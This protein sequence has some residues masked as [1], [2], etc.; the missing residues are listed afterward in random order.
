[1]TPYGGSTVTDMISKASVGLDLYGG[2]TVTQVI[3]DTGKLL[4]ALASP[5]VPAQEAGG[6]RFSASSG[7]DFFAGTSKDDRINGE[8]GDDTLYGGAGNDSLNGGLGNDLLSG[9]VGSD[10]LIGG[11]GAD[12]LNGGVGTDMLVGGVGADVFA[13][14]AGWGADRVLDFKAG[15][16]K[17]DLRA[18][19]I[20]SIAELT[21]TSSALGVTLQHGSDTILLHGVQLGSLHASDFIWA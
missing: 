21:I 19:G 13:F 15:S 10:T 3:A 9:G 8:W 7:N 2:K 12:T 11:S 18:A 4:P 14:G 20:H 1:M 5:M 6:Q 17:L 16:D